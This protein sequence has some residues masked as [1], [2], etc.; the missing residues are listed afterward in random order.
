MLAIFLIFIWS[1]QGS[2]L[3]I[4]KSAPSN[5]CVLLHNLTA[6][7]TITLV[8]EFLVFQ[9]FNHGCHIMAVCVPGPDGIGIMGND[10]YPNCLK[11]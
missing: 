9:K 2:G 6:H 1:T 4:V 10:M 5:E 11:L 7:M 8:I 3:V